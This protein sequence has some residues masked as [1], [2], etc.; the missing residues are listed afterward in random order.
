MWQTRLH[1]ASQAD[2]VATLSILAKQTYRFLPGGP[3]VADHA[4][5][6]P[7]FQTDSF[8][9]NPDPTQSPPRHLSEF[10]PPK[11]RVDVVLHGN[12]CAPRGKQAK[13]FDAGFVV[14]TKV[15]RFRAFGVRRL[16]FSAGA[17]HFSEP[18]PFTHCPLHWGMAYG[19]SSWCNELDAFAP[20]PPNPVGLGFFLKGSIEP[21]RP[22][23]LPRLENPTHPLVESNI[24]V[25]GA[26]A[27]QG[28]PRPV[29]PGWR[30]RHAIPR[31]DEAN[32]AHPELQFDRISLGEP[33]SFHYLD[34][35]H[36]KFDISLPTIRPR[37]FLDSGSGAA[38]CQ[39]RLQT[40]EIFKP[41]NQ[42]TMLWRADAALPE[43]DAEISAP[44]SHWAID[45]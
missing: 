43:P 38:E 17:A 42:L 31:H 6:I 9:G 18:E 19:G 33:I 1:S 23:A 7:W 2:G 14:G 12:A 45:T 4:E 15:F 28:Q 3:C 44:M 39:P 11:T 27:W 16:V 5:P 34:P 40:I 36:P 35:D 30:P 41:S 26:S 10:S 24:L 21:T 25:D 22:L 13:F 20:F 32:G 8:I 29:S 37:I